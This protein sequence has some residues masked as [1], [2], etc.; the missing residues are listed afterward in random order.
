MLGRPGGLD[1]AARTAAPAAF[2][3]AA[4]FFAWVVLAGGAFFGAGVDAMSRSVP[5]GGLSVEPDRGGDWS[6]LYSSIAAL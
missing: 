1:G 4:G 3:G 6:A 2:L 5:G